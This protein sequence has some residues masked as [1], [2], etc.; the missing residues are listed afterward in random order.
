[1][2]S[3]R[4]KDRAQQNRQTMLDLVD[5]LLTKKI[6]EN[7]LPGTTWLELGLEIHLEAEAPAREAAIKSVAETA[8]PIPPG[9]SIA[10]VF[11]AMDESL[12]IL[13]EP[14][15][16]KSMM[17]LE[18][19]RQAIAQARA[20]PT[21]PIPVILNLSSWA[22]SQ[23]LD[24]WLAVELERRYRVPK[25][26]ARD[27]VKN[28]ELLLLL[29]GLDEV[30]SI[31]RKACLKAINRFYQ[32]HSASLAV[33]SR[34]AEYEMLTLR[35]KLQGAV[36][37]QPLTF[38]EVNAYLSGTGSDIA[39]AR[40]MLKEDEALQ[41][42]ARSPL[43]LS[44][45]VLAYRGLSAEDLLALDTAEARRKHLFE[46]YVQQAFVHRGG[47]RPYLPQQSVHWLAWLAK[48][49]QQHN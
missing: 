39:A 38:E 30:A 6:Q 41:E 7:L 9:T 31:R 33:C 42:L 35:L 24:N 12:L 13:G 25:K 1:M 44:L 17:L 16:G 46:T 28:D 4:G 14:G 18:L 3:N 2:S 19:A 21:R 34:T 23:A 27:W 22:T 45:M 36:A 20:D 48:K 10:E 32:K 11:A 26:V 43:M 40:T 49:M 29:D 47:D 37:L 15:S 8:R 5:A